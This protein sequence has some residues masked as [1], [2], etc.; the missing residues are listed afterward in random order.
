MTQRPRSR[1]ALLQQVDLP[2]VLAAII[3]PTAV[4]HPLKDW[5]TLETSGCSVSKTRRETETR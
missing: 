4:R 5:R 2:A 3:G 1:T